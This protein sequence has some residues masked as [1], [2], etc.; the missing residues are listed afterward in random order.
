MKCDKM[1][2]MVR[3][4]FNKMLMDKQAKL[5]LFV[6]DFYLSMNSALW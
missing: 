3:A 4:K 1:D 2:N 6:A 5:T